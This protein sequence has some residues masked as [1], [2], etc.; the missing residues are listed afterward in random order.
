MKADFDMDAS[1]IF[2]QGVLATIILIGSV[3][4]VGRFKA[5]TV[6]KARLPLCSMAIAA[7]S[8]VGSAT[9]SLE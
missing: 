4:G 2:P 5:Y 1:H 6:H 3:V 8:G 9:L 7:L